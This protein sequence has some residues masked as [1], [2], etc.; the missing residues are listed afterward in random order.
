MAH[1]CFISF[2][3]EDQYYRDKLDSLFDDE[4][5]INKSLNRVIDSENG[6]YIMQVIRDDYLKDS[7]VTIF[8]IGEHSSENEG[9][10]W[11]G[12]KNYFIKKELQSSLYNGVGNTRSGILGVVLPEMYDQIYRGKYTCSSCGKDH[13]YVNIDDDT[14]IK[15]FSENYYL[16][17]HE[18]CAWSEDERYCVLVKWNDFINDPEYYI[19][20]AFNKRGTDLSKK[21][22][23]NINRGFIKKSYF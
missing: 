13:N 4:D 6:N 11:K 15:E 23:V 17:P 2:K 21:V 9:S 3:K 1:K 18:G 12:D 16:E 19:N 8:L 10:D 14:V 7:T 22:H 20:F 5:V